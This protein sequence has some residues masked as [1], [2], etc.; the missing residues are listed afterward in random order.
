MQVPV[1]ID[2]FLVRPEHEHLEL[3][4]GALVERA[5]PTVEHSSA[6]GGIIRL[7]GDRFSRKAGGRVPG[8]WWLLPSLDIRLG[9]EVFTPD[10]C[11]FRR[12]RDAALPQGRL[13][14]P[15]PDWVCEILS[16][17]FE[18]RD[19]VEKLQSYFAAGV[20]HYWLVNPIEGTL[21]VLRRTDL[22]YALVLSA[23]RGQTVKAEPFDA[24]E[25]RVDELLGGDPEDY[26]AL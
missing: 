24:I 11:G 16:P 12:D 15:R 17:G 19:R 1:T 4:R 10:V 7:T 13:N 5:A 23:H 14:L 8:G 2:G 26:R 18:A 6:L 25:V 9:S 21:E 22:A 20:P 3:L